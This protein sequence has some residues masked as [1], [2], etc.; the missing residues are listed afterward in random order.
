[1]YCGGDVER[2][3][4]AG[5]STFTLLRGKI[6]W[7]RLRREVHELHRCVKFSHA[8]NAE[9]AKANKI[10]VR[11]LSFLLFWWGNQPE[12]REE[13]EDLCGFAELVV[14]FNGASF[15]AKSLSCGYAKHISIV[16]VKGTRQYISGKHAQHKQFPILKP[17]FTHSFGFRAIG[18]TQRPQEP[19]EYSDCA[20]SIASRTSKAALDC[21][22]QSL[23]HPRQDSC[24]ARP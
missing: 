15:A 3:A 23:C 7:R 17:L 24:R 6:K 12:A 16:I 4:T 19:R 21:D 2:L 13:R 10:R 1:M 22:S 5:P 11:F 18:S 9:V 14:F 20:I 8:K